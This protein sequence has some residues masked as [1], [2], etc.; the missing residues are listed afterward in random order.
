MRCNVI[1]T[2]CRFIRLTAISFAVFAVVPYLPILA[3]ETLR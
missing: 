1:L 3:W 2:I